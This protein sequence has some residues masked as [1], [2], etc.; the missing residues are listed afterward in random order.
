MTK[1]EIMKIFLCKIEREL[2]QV[3]TR[4]TK[5]VLRDREYPGLSNFTFEEILAE[6]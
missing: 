1:E 4:D 5:S 2:V 6:M 3:A